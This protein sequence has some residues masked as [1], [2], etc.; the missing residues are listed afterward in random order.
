[1]SYREKSVWA[2]VLVTVLVWGVYFLNLSGHVLN[3]GG[4]EEP[5]FAGAWGGRFVETLIAAIIAQ[6]I[7]TS[8]VG[9]LTPKA[10][11]Q[12]RDERERAYRWRSQAV[13][14]H[15][16]IILLFSLGF[17][18][19]AAGGLTGAMGQE[20]GTPALQTL[21]SNSLVLAANGVVAAVILAEL[22]AFS[23][24]LFLLRRGR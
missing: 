3:G 5:G 7:L 17:F 8:I 6:I 22:V 14:F 16:L 4:L 1:M 18:L 24:E 13:G 11:R 20:G 15:A 21:T 10:E 12:A 23:M 2:E 19:F 9:A